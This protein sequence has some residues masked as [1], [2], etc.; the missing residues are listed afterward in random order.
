MSETEGRN[1]Y[2]HC[3]MMLSTLTQLERKCGDTRAY[4]D[5]DI[6]EQE[7]LRQLL[8]AEIQAMEQ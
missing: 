3:E 2:Y 5:V 1:R 6:G 8:S 4:L 7:I